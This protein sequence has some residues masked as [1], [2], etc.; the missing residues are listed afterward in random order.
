MLRVVGLL[1]R[2]RLFFYADNLLRIVVL[3]TCLPKQRYERVAK[4]P[5]K[6]G[7]LPCA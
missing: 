5:G 3:G 4:E 6:T 2:P 7:S 1:R